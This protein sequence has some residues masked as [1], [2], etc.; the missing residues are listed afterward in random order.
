MFVEFGDGKRH[1]EATLPE[2]CEHKGRLYT[3]NGL[4][5]MT[6]CICCISAL[7]KKATVTVRQV[8]TK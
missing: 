1:Y 5:T 4:L 7:R 8:R 3:L 6:L 2:R